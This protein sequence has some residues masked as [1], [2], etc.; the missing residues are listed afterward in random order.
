MIYTARPYAGE[1]DLP[2]IVALLDA[3]EAVDHLEDGSSVEQLRAEF[4]YPRAQ[5]EK[6]V[7]LWRDGQ[8]RVLG[9]ARLWLFEPGASQDGRLLTLKVHPNARGGSLEAELLGWA[10]ARLREVGR[11][12]GLPSELQA[13]IRDD[14]TEQIAFLQAHGFSINRYFWTMARSLEQPIPAPTLPAGF[15][16]RQVAGAEDAERWVTLFNEA[17]SDHWN[18]H[19]MTVAHFLHD[20]SLP[21]YHADK[22][23]LVLAPDG[24]FAA[25][26]YSQI[27]PEENART[28]RSEGWV[29]ALGTGRAFRKLGLGRALLLD[30]LERLRAAG[31]T[32]AKLGVDAASLTGA[33]RLYES[34]G[35][36]VVETR[37]ALAKR[38][39]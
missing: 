6:N 12:V 24:T 13:R 22:D 35:F 37:V 34:V 33:N 17:W 31:M 5:P 39:P 7:C 36:R 3:C 32:T 28:G 38:L 11:E 8:G 19:L 14:Q 27:S 9:Y 26:C 18:G 16:M 30:G 2:L 20:I 4:A 1:A 23:R 29:E 25:F 15:T 21:D 10:E